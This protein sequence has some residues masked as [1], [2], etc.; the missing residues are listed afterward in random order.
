MKI[1]ED[2]FN[3]KFEFCTYVTLGSFDGFHLGHLE[4]INKTNELSNKLGCKSMIFTFKNHPLSIINKSKTP[5]II[6]NDEE[7]IEIVN[8][9]G[10]DILNLANF[11]EDFMKMYPSEFIHKLVYHYNVKGLVVGFNYKFGY[12]NE[13]DIELLRILSKKLNFKLT[14]IPPIKLGD[15]IISSSRIRRLISDG[16]IKEANLL[17]G[18][19]FMLSGNVIEGKKIGRTIGFPT[20]NLDYD[21]KYIIPANGVYYTNTEI[22]NNF[23]KSITNIGFNPTVNGKNLSIETNVL[24]FNKEIYGEKVKIYF[25]ERIRDEK[26][27]DSIEQLSLQLRIDKELVKQKPFNF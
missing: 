4:L 5:K 21:D 24:D 22:N 20:I 6:L 3:R 8:N 23:Y 26:K 15:D 17:L 14:V 1:L 7:K 25:I 10:I 12:K 2:N 11:N 16:N 19:Y 18:R 9:T 27:F 13:G